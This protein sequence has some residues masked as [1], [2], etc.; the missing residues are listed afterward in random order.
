M[1]LRS[2]LDC[3]SELWLEELYQWAD[4]NDIPELQ[5]IPNEEEAD[6][7]A[8]VDHGFWVG[9][10]RNEET[11]K[12]I[13]E[14]DLSWHNCSEIPNQLRNL[15]QLQTLRFCKS[16]DG[17]Q[18]PFFKIAEKPKMITEIPLWISELVNLEE[19][20]LSLNQIRFV[21]KE[22]GELKK[23]KRL[24]LRGNEITFIGE[25]LQPLENLET[26]WLNWNRNPKL[27]EK[28]KKSLKN[29]RELWLNNLP[30]AEYGP[31]EKCPDGL[32]LITEEGYQ[33]R[34][35][36]YENEKLDQEGIAYILSSLG[37]LR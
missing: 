26:L 24:F 28:T 23:L 1:A 14:L 8:I 7:G 17:V 29:L 10:P 30:G 34:F 33:V 15:T 6:D 2:S 13:K 11:L 21:P 12:S 31:I 37:M 36:C 19:L 5:F 3:K 27:S 32:K 9:L 35:I 25:S 16:Q 18:P 20:D 4:K 22:I